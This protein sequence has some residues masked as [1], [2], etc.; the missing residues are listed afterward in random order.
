MYADDVILFISPTT[1]DALAIQH[2]L[3]VFSEASG[4]KTHLQKCSITPIFGDETVLRDVQEILQCKIDQFP[5]R[6]LG[7]PLSTRKL[8]KAHFQSQWWMQ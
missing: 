6:Y 1:A 5:I 4:L 7:L 3:G 2:I 8:P